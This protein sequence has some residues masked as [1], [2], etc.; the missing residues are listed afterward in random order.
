MFSSWLKSRFTFLVAVAVEKIRNL[1]GVQYN[2]VIVNSLYKMTR[3]T[4]CYEILVYCVLK[5]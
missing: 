3:Y 1:A 5:Q 4:A 2:C